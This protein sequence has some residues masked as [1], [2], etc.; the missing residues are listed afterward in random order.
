MRHSASLFSLAS[1]HQLETYEPI[2]FFLNP[3]NYSKKVK[4]QYMRSFLQNNKLIDTVVYYLQ[5]ERLFPSLVTAQLEEESILN[6]SSF[7]LATFLSVGG[8]T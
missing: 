6:V 5:G 4:R 1:F 7:S 3:I 2:T 8:L